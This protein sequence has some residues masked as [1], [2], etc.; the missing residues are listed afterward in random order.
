MVRVQ[1]E[2]YN[3]EHPGATNRNHIESR[4]SRNQTVIRLVTYISTLIEVNV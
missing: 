3:E 1:Y 2:F 4:L